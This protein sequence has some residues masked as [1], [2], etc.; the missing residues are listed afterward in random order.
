MDLQQPAS[1]SCE[2]VILRA[3]HHDAPVCAIIAPPPPFASAPLSIR[4]GRHR[5]GHS[6]TDLQLSV[7]TQSTGV[8]VSVCPLCFCSVVDGA[9]AARWSNRM[10]NRIG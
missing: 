5:D 3:L 2:C 4:I 8:V 7:G 6:S 10:T 1:R 9:R